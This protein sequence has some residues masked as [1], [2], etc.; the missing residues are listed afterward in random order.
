MSTKYP[1]ILAHGIAAKD[2]RIM[3]AF[4][5]IGDELT[6]AGYSVHIAD[7]DGF[8]TIEGNAQQ[9]K[10]FILRVL[11]ETGCEKVNIIAQ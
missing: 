1:I 10:D 11:S 2:A 3:N 6:K 9:L 7:T 4:G 8:G 5:H